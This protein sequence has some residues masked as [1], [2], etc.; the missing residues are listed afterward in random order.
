MRSTSRNPIGRKRLMTGVT[1]VVLTLGLAPVAVVAAASPAAAAGRCYQ[2]SGGNKTLTGDASRVVYSY[3]CSSSGVKV[4]GTVY[5]TSCDSRTGYASVTV[6][7]YL[8]G[9]I[10]TNLWSKTAKA[11][12]GCNTYGEFNYS[13]EGTDDGKLEVCTWAANNLGSSSK[14][15]KTWL[16]Y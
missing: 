9:G 12:N 7:D 16:L 1:A 6:K 10:Y 14:S 3:S 15:C 13:G 2:S 8:T 11:A 5:D 4:S